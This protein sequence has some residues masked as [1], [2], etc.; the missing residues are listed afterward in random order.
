MGIFGRPEPFQ[1]APIFVGGDGRSGT[2]LLSLILDS[3]SELV[4]G[5]ELHFRGPANLGASCVEACDLLINSD[6]R[7]RSP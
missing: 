3:N 7:A 4:V 2:T 6:P 5:P 1:S